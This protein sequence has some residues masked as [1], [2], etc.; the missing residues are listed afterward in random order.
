MTKRPENIHD[1]YHAHVYFGP[2]TSV[3]ARQFC[4]AVGGTFDV[5]VGR[6]H[7]KPVGPHPHW[8]CQVSFDT[9]MFDKLIGWMDANRGELDIFVH[10]QT[11]NDLDDHTVYAT[12]LGS[13]AVLN[14][15][16]LGGHKTDNRPAMITTRKEL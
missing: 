1:K 10:G 13:P 6:F 14:L 4:D 9:T 5:K 7:E 2:K 3:A 8:S 15:A 16:S 12:W 11:G